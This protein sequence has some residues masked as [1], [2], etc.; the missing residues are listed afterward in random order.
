MDSLTIICTPEVIPPYRCRISEWKAVM[1]SSVLAGGVLCYGT[2][3][4]GYLAFRGATQ[5]DI[6]DNFMGPI[7]AFFKILVIV[8]LILYIPN[9]VF[10]LVP[11]IVY[12]Q[13]SQS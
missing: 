13:M 3:L 4:A 2:G 11:H 1:T 8:H 10:Y 12:F 9:E 7:A 6:L 5:G